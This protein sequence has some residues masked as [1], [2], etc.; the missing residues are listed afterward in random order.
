MNTLDDHLRDASQAW[1]REAAPAIAASAEHIAPRVRP[2]R[3]WTYG[4][5][6]VGALLLVGTVWWLASSTPSATSVPS[7]TPTT[8]RPVVVEQRPVISTAPSTNVDPPSVTRSTPPP[9]DTHRLQA[10]GGDDGFT[11]E[12]ERVLAHAMSIESA[13]PLAAASQYMGL[14]RMCER[15]ERPA[16]AVSAL[17][18]AAQLMP[19]IG[20]AAMAQRI[21]AMLR[22]N[23]ARLQP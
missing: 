14:A 23:R 20:D 4:L 2:T 16:H 12:Y 5:G 1:M 21:D 15:R 17:E 8:S 18:R 11:V 22:T 13:D 10:L 19:R 6:S 9:S 7:S 3:G